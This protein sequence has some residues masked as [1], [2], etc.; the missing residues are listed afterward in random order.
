MRQLPICIQID[1]TSASA[2]KC[3]KSIKYANDMQIRQLGAVLLSW[4]YCKLLHAPQ[5]VLW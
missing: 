1:L 3:H 4:T 5:A 2:N